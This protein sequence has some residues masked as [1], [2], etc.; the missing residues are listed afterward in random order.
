MWKPFQV[1]KALSM[2]LG[3]RSMT[4]ND[5]REDGWQDT[6]MR[7][8][9]ILGVVGASHAPGSGLHPRKEMRLLQG[10]FLLSKKDPGPSSYSFTPK[11]STWCFHSSARIRVVSVCQ[12]SL[13]DQTW[14]SETSPKEQRKPV[15]VTLFSSFQGYTGQSV[16]W[17]PLP[18]FPLQEELALA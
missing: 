9:R 3:K 5:F 12:V 6:E 2:F 10:G 16:C 4:G 1:P 18:Q 17:S 8:L 13:R 11:A 14:G 7:K 15:E